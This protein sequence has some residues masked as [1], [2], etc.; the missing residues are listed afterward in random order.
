MDIAEI[1][2]SARLSKSPM[3]VKLLSGKLNKRRMP[4]LRRLKALVREIG[5]RHLRT[6]EFTETVTYSRDAFLE[7]VRG[8]PNTSLR[9]MSD[10][11]FRRRYTVLETAVACQEQ[12]TEESFSTLLTAQK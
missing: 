3:H 5:F 10:E 1:R 12:C 8:K 6:E 2:L 7:K 9:S 4:S 11:D